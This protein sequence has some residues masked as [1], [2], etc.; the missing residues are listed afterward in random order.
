LSPKNPTLVCKN[1][2]Q[3]HKI[4]I[5]ETAVEKCPEPKAAKDFMGRNTN[6]D[7]RDVRDSLEITVFSAK[8][9]LTALLSA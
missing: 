4:N 7:A 2:G 1:A 5:Q 6:I 8:D 3:G 9:C